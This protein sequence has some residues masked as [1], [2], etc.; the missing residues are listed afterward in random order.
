MECYKHW[1]YTNSYKT[2]FGH[3]K[4][5]AFNLSAQNIYGWCMAMLRAGGGGGGATVKRGEYSPTSLKLKPCHCLFTKNVP[6]AIN[7]SLAIG[8]VDNP[9]TLQCLGNLISTTR[10]DN[11][12]E[13]S[14]IF[15][16]LVL[17]VSNPTHRLLNWLHKQP[18]LYSYCCFSTTSHVHVCHIAMWA[19]QIACACTIIPCV[20]FGNPLRT[21]E[22]VAIGN[23]VVNQRHH[24]ET[25]M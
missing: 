4:K 22:T 25:W 7:T 9:W 20:L 16:I 2:Q 3:L 18:I 8:H 10:I 5:K 21:L 17:T 6:N 14:L 24:D 13:I 11:Y 23:V 15:L 12:D 1:M 19:G